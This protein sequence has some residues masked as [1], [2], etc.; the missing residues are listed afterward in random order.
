MLGEDDTYEQVNESSSRLFLLFFPGGVT[1][2]GGDGGVNARGKKGSASLV[3]FSLCDDD[4]RSESSEEGGSDSSDDKE[5]DRIKN[6]RVRSGGGTVGASTELTGREHADVV[7][8]SF[9]ERAG[10]RCSGA[11]VSAG[12]VGRYRRGGARSEPTSAAGGTGERV[13]HVGGQTV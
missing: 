13:A 5:V 2:K 3:L 4:G 12:R 7:R 10:R 6:P 9:S 1:G 8:S 11:H